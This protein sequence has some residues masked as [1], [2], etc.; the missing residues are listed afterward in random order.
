MTDKLD[1]RMLLS[2]NFALSEDEMH[3]LNQEEFAKVFTVGLG[4]QAG[5][6]CEFVR[7]P[8]WVVD[9][10]YETSQY[11]PKDVGQLCADTLAKYRT[12]QQVK[13]F[14]VM[15]LGGLKTTPPT[16]SPPALQ[17]G[18]WGVDIV[19]TRSPE[20]FLEEIKWDKLTGAKSAENV[21][22]IDHP[23]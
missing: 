11:T 16:G 1:G 17:T 10:R 9:V 12:A 3:S 20:T 7:N 21:F 2:H 23:V 14:V 8:H 18:E 6:S 5:I 19:E 15:A 4:S 22:R 13:G